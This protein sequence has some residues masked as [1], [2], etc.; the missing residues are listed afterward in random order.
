MSKYNFALKD[1][2]IEKSNPF[3][4]DYKLINPPLKKSKI[5]TKGNSTV[6]IKHYIFKPR[7]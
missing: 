5:L 2:A 4:D 7:K 1:L 6:F 3:T